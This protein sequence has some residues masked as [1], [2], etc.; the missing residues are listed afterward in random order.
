MRIS[1]VDGL[2]HSRNKQLCKGE[3]SCYIRCYV[4][5]MLPIQKK[6]LAPSL[7]SESDGLARTGIAMA[8][9]CWEI[10]RL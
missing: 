4:R 3:I 7:S 8:I 1:A 5:C 2:R 9:R 6:S 10:Q